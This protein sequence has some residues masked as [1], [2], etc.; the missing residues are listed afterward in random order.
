MYDYSAAAT[1]QSLIESRERLGLERIDI[2]HIHDVI[3]LASGSEPRQGGE[4]RETYPVLAELRHAGVI[5]AAG[6]GAQVNQV[7]ID[8]GV[9]VLVRLLSRSPAATRFSISPPSRRS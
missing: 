9:G 1:R 6:V 7:L 8:L 2:A 4:I 3:E 5:A